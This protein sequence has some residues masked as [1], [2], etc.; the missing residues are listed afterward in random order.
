MVPWQPLASASAVLSLL[1]GPLGDLGYFVVWSRFRMLRRYLA[2]RSEEL[3]VRKGSTG[4]SLLDVL[5]SQQ[6]LHTSHVRERDKALL[7]SILVGSVCG[8]E[9]VSPAWSSEERSFG[10]VFVVVLMAMG[11]FFWECLYPLLIE[12][13]EN[14]EIYDPHENG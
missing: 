5:G 6:L 3:C 12:S 8:M 13:R 10:A 9:R 4:G 1:D 7:R 11:T 2:N 14:P